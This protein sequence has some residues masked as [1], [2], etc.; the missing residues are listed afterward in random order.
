MSSVRVK[1]GEARKAGRSR[2]SLCSL[3]LSALS[4][5]AVTQEKEWPKDYQV[6]IDLSLN[7][8]PPGKKYRRPYLAV[9]VENEKGRRIRTLTVWGRKTKYIRTLTEWWRE[10]PRS[11]RE[12]DAITR[13]T[14]RPGRYS[15]VWDG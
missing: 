3:F 11:R 2:V 5:G 15:I 12:V 1:G 9:W 10:R 13:P 14:R 8:R 7:K 4:L 6:T